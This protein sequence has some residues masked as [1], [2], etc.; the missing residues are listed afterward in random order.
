MS[1]QSKTEQP[2]AKEALRL[3]WRAAKIWWELMPK[4]LIY[5]AWGA[6][7]EA[8]APYLSLWFSA[9]LLG[10]VAGACSDLVVLTEIYAAREQNTI[11]ISSRDLA[12]Q[13]PGSLY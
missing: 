8:S 1:K 7:F 13:I 6:F 11:G 9:Q 2:S 3:N 5:K 12:A 4:A 10:E